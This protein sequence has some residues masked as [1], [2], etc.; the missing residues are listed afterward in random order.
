MAELLIFRE[1]IPGRTGVG[2]REEMTSLNQAKFLVSVVH[3]DGNGQEKADQS[4]DWMQ[5][6]SYNYLWLPV[7]PTVGWPIKKYISPVCL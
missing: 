2:I 4:K 5:V 7:S 1:N 6:G 3:L